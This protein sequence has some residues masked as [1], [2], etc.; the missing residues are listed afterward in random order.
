MK[1]TLIT[2]LILSSLILAN[3][4]RTQTIGVSANYIDSFYKGKSE[5]RPLPLLNLRLN[6]F[7]IKG[8]L[9]VG[10]ILYEEP[11]FSI[12]L[13][14]NP[15]SG[16]FDGWSVKSSKMNDGYKNIKNRDPQ[17]MGGLGIDFAFDEDYTLV[18]NANY[19]F[20]SKGSA[21]VFNLSKIF[22]PHERLAIIPS[23][24]LKIKDKK[25]VNYFTSVSK[26]EAENNLAIEKSHSG[27]MSIGAGANLT[28]EF[29]LT[30]TFLANTFIGAEYISN[31][32]ESPIV[33]KNHQIYGGLGIRISF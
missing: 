10:F 24:T 25:Y 29:A 1:K 19:T 23:G 31:I 13:I 21:G 9:E 18:G 7:T 6:R 14:G 5:I 22:L 8:P 30:E 32:D 20:G 16:Y 15:L 3:E 27:K 2:S 12:S 26:K 17:L 4:N 33:E 11:R 28:L